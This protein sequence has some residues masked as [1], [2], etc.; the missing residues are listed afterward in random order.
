MFSTNL[1]PKDLVDGASCGGFRIRSRSATRPAEFYELMKI[2]CKVLKLPFQEAPVQHLITEHYEKP[3]R[4][5]RCCQP[6]DLLMQVRNYCAYKSQPI[7]LTE[8]AFDFA[9]ANYFS[10]M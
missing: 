8:E 1:E 7:E 4:P 2:M 6:R 5:Y 3:S 9:V 10:V